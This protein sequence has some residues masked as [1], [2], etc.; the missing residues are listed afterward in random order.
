MLRWITLNFW[1]LSAA[2]TSATPNSLASKSAALPA[3]KP[4]P[5]ST[6]RAPPTSDPNLA[7]VQSLLEQPEDQIDL[8]RAKL[9][10]DRMVNSSVDVEKAVT[11]IDA[12]ASEVRQML[13]PGASSWDKMMT[14]RQ[15]LYIP[16]V[17]N[18]NNPFHYNFEDVKGT[19]L[20]DK[21]LPH[22]LAT[23]KGQCVS[24]PALYLVI[25]QR[26][27]MNVAL[28]QAPNHT[29]V[30]LKNDDGTWVNLE[31]TADGAPT[32]LATYQRQM[33]MSQKALDNGVYM[34][35]LGRRETVAT[36]AEELTQF[37]GEQHRYEQVIAL[38]ELRLRY[39]PTDVST[40]IYES[41]AYR[42][43]AFRD[44]ISK[45]PRSEDLPK[46]Q[47]P[48]FNSL[49]SRS[50]EFRQRAVDLGFQPPTQESEDAYVR[51]V[52]R[53]KDDMTKGAQ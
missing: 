28:A 36:M 44:Y 45:Y 6:T 33:P 14:L 31:T 2:A 30:M 16:G 27:G 32:K 29:F 17:W 46:D 50:M 34:R 7:V 52:V 40:L 13:P 49:A 11:A 37:Y 53:A 42:A 1:M 23:R 48:R 18:G 9:T 43:T 15:Y 5:P 24:M 10:I 12:M 51:K 22:Y 41:D 25:A 47:I 8:T 3:N 38:A 19:D 20:Q 26:L 35:P 39:H 4:P 21:L